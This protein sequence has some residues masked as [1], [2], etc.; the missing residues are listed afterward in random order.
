MVIKELPDPRVLL[1]ETDWNALGTSYGESGEDGS[2]GPGLSTRAALGAF[3]SGDRDAI[4]RVLNRIGDALLHQNTLYGATGPATLYVAALLAD[5][6]SREALVP[7]WEAGL[8]P[9]RAKLLDWLAEGGHRRALLLGVLVPGTGDPLLATR[10][11][12]GGFRLP[13]RF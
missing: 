9:L 10:F 7:A 12:P 5:P 11:L 8:R 4:T 2:F 1:A 6:G 13:R 3:T